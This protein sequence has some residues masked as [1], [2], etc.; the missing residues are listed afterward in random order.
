M[1]RHLDQGDTKDNVKI[2]KGRPAVF[3]KD[4][5]DIMVNHK[6]INETKWIRK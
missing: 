4:F 5:E 3:D 2:N 1:K 6:Q